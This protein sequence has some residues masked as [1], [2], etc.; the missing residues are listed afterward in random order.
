MSSI[1]K[2]GSEY[3]F[4]GDLLIEKNNGFASGN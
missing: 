1:E 3:T 2:P 4:L